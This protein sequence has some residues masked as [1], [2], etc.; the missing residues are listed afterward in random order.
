MCRYFYVGVFIQGT[1]VNAWSGN[2]ALFSFIIRYYD[3]NLV[4]SNFDKAKATI[5]SLQAHGNA[6]T[7][8]TSYWFVYYGF[9]VSSL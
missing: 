7:V 8:V 6:N 4:L 5:V 1:L 2:R 9:S 3:E